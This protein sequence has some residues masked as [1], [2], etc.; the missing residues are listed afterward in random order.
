VTPTELKLTAI[1]KGP[2]VPLADICVKY[3][4]NNYETASRKAS[5]NALPFPAFKLDESNFKSPWVVRVTDLAFFVDQKGNAA[6]ME[7]DKSQV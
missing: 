5:V 1:H 2:V 3:L 6:A 4:G 7:W